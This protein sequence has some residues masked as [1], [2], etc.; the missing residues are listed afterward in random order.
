MKKVKDVLELSLPWS[1]GREVNLI[2]ELLQ[3]IQVLFNTSF[4]V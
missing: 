4:L 3:F 2:L 1:G